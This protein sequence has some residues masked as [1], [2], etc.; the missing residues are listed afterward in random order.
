VLFRYKPAAKMKSVTLAGTFNEWNIS[1]H[2]LDGPDEEGYF[3]T[4]LRLKAGTYEYKF[5][6]EGK[7]WMSDPNNYR[8]TGPNRNS[9]LTV[10]AAQP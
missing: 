9:V 3:S 7:T 8:V 6:L 4:R 1:A 5:V 2:A 10:G